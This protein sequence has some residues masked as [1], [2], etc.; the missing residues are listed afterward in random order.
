MRR[1]RKWSASRITFE[2]RTDDIVIARRTI[3]KIL[4]NFGL[5]RRRFID[6]NGETNRHPSHRRQ[7]ARTDGPRRHQECWKDSRRWRVARSR[8]RFRAGQ[9]TPA[10]EAKNKQARLGSTYLH[11]TIDGNTRLAYTDAQEQRNR[12]NSHRF[13]EQ[14][15]TLLRRTR[16]HPDRARDHRQRVMLSGIRFHSFTRKLSTPTD[17][18]VHTEIQS[19]NGTLQPRPRRR[20]ALLSRECTSEQQQ[21]TA[22]Q[23]WNA[24]YNY[25]RPHSTRGARP[26][27]ATAS[28]VRASYT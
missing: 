26:P 27:A 11:S 14:R 23:V 6:Q 4:R 21:R 16:H 7:T 12:I 13:H 5:N 17:R 18:A 22:V 25:H 3:T 19:E 9:T 10:P 2:P 15:P 20:T 28:N 8:T 24:H 1:T